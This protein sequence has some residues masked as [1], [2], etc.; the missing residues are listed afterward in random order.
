MAQLLPERWKH[1]LSNLRSDIQHALERWLP[2]RRSDEQ[3]EEA[4][5]VKVHEAVSQLRDDITQAL[6][7]WLPGRQ[8]PGS[9]TGER[10]PSFFTKAGPVIDVE[11]T[12]HEIIVLAEM[13][14]LDKDDFS[15]ELTADRLVLRGEKRHEVEEQ[16][17]GYS[18]SERSF[19]AFARVIPL[20][21]DVAAEKAQATYKNGLLRISLPKTEWAQVKRVQ[22][23]IR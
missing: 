7:R 19:G 3:G 15:V 14:G 1:A 13:P 4:L 6:E 8:Q 21:C 22:V 16:R 11:E 9:R 18:Y 10:M 12:D 17:G 20:P 23:Q 5:P 2:S